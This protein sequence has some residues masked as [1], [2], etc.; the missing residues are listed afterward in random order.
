MGLRQQLSKIPIIKYFVPSDSLVEKGMDWVK[1]F[2]NFGFAALT[3]LMIIYLPLVIANE[4]EKQ[5]L[6]KL[7]G[8]AYG[9]KLENRSYAGGPNKTL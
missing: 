2:G 4:Q 8:A 3:T 7:V 5:S 1:Y 9:V 6:Y